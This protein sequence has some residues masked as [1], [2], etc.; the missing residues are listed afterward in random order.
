MQ[1]NAQGAPLD[2]VRIRR[3]ERRPEERKPGMS[4]KVE[5]ISALLRLRESP[6][7]QMYNGD[8]EVGPFRDDPRPIH[9]RGGHRDGQPGG[10]GESAESG[11]DK[12]ANSVS[13]AGERRESPSF[14]RPS[15]SRSGSWNDWR[16]DHS[17]G[18]DDSGK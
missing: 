16:D 11:P 4:P 14:P 8:D 10:K 15:N 9:S 17:R 13:R 2:R 6:H 5:G 3:P 7:S 12:R 18:G 1:P